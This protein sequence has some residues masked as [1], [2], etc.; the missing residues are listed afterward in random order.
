M[1][2]ELVFA[3]VLFVLCAGLALMMAFLVSESAR[4]ITGGSPFF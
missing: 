4:L 1:R 2:A 3:L